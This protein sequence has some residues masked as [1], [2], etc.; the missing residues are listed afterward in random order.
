[1]TVWK[2]SSRIHQCLWTKESRR[3]GYSVPFQH[4]NAV[5]NPQ[6]KNGMRKKGHHSYDRVGWRVKSFRESSR[7]KDERRCTQKAK[8]GR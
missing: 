5:P 3:C 6:S 2:G 4:E 8:R 7:D 1:M